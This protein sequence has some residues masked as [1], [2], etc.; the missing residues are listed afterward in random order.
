M[1]SAHGR[2]FLQRIG[3]RLPIFQAPMAGVSSPAM[4]AAVSNSGGLGSL[5]FG[6]STAGNARLAIQQLRRLSAGPLN[7]N[8]FVHRP[9]HANSQKGLRWLARLAPE[10]ERV[11]ASAPT[12]LREIYRSFRVDDDMLTVLIEE[13][14]TAV[15]FHFGLPTPHQLEALQKAGIALLASVTNLNEALAAKAAGIEAL[16]AQGYEAGGHR[17]IF[18]PDV[19]DD[20]L[21]TFA[22][23]R[24][25]AR[26]VPLPIV[27][28][29]GI[30]DGAGIC[31]ALTLGA[32]AAQ[33]GTAF[34]GSAESMAGTAY[35]ARLFSEAAHRTVMTRV[36]S[37]RPARCLANDFTAWGSAIGPDEIPDY[38]LAYGAANALDLAATAAGR[39]GYGAQWAGQ[40]APLARAMPAHRLMQALEEELGQSGWGEDRN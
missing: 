36:L 2:T 20:C 28:A 37:G 33:L 8:V 7:A 3:V 25:L 22:L 24:V 12:E 11:G 1:V 16:V 31:A 38:P 40:G 34:V 35:R 26:A 6:A 32:C 9:P 21:G 15:S 14:P 30:M 39:T 13:R 17:G 10:F 18:D 19:P 29:G 23:I 27:A 4:A 5:A